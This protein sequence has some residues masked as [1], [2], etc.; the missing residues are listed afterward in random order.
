MYA[1]KVMSPRRFKGYQSYRE[2]HDTSAVWGNVRAPGG[3]KR[4]DRGS[5]LYMHR[6]PLT[7]NARLFAHRAVQFVVFGGLSLVRRRAA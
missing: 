5:A 6:K 2:L 7:P 3:V 4:G 1:G